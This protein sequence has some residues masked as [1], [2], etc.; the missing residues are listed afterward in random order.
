MPT[1]QGTNR[2]AG[3]KSSKLNLAFKPAPS[4]IAV[5]S[6]AQLSWRLNREKSLSDHTI[7]VTAQDVE[8]PMSTSYHVHR[9]ILSV[10]PRYFPNRIDLVCL[11]S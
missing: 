5:E 4:S 1:R 3:G 10:G 7:N 11:S 6:T 8:S 2:R 9:S